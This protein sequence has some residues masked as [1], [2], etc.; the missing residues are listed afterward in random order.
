[1]HQIYKDLQSVNQID[2]TKGETRKE[3]EI[4]CIHESSSKM[5]HVENK[6]RQQF[7]CKL[8]RKEKHVTPMGPVFHP[9][10]S[11]KWNF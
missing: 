2:E 4:M 5:T 9:F 3:I 6:N 7:V 10:N 1:M 11:G 8:I